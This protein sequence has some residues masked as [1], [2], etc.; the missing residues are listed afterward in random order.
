ML[1]LPDPKLKALKT[2]SAIVHDNYHAI[3]Q[4]GDVLLALMRSTTNVSHED[5]QL[6]LLLCGYSQV[7]L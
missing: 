5:S 2:L 3:L 6:L 1:E 4:H 7:T